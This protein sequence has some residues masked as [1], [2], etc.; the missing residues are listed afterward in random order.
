MHIGYKNEN[1]SYEISDGSEEYVL[2]EATAE[3]DLG[4]IISSN[5]K[6]EIK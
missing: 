2:E 3:R 4:V 1:Y 5:L 6:F